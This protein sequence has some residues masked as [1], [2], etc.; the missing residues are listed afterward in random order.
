M[1]NTENPPVAWSADYSSE[2]DLTLVAGQVTGVYT[3]WYDAGARV[4]DITDPANPAQTYEYDPDG[5]RS[6]PPCENAASPSSATSAARAQPAQSVHSADYVR[7]HLAMER[8]A[9]H[10][11]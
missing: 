8:R 6:G 10:Y 4:Y 3:S 7:R 2:R 9:C 11:R 5:Y 1:L